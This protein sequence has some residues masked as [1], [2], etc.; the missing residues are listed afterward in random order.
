[1]NDINGDEMVGL[2][3]EHADIESIV[4]FKDLMNR[5]GCENL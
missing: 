3:G 1:M 5:L 2:I 4:A